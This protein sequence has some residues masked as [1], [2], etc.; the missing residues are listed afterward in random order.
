MTQFVAE[1]SIT[2]GRLELSNVPFENDVNVKVIV[3]PKANLSKMS[4]PEMWEATKS[5]QGKL[6]TDINFERNER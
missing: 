1:A 5:I 3:I 2:N 6:I 4:I